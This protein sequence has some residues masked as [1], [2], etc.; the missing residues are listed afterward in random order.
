MQIGKSSISGTLHVAGGHCS[1]WRAG[2]CEARFCAASRGM[3]VA[4]DTAWLADQFYVGVMLEC[5]RRGRR[6]LEAGCVKLA[7]GSCSPWV[8]QL[9]EYPAA[10]TAAV[11]I[12]N[13]RGADCETS[14]SYPIRLDDTTELVCGGVRL[15][16]PGPSSE[17]DAQR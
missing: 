11:G 5:A 9:L 10:G 2:G 7:N 4:A 1:T 17:K 6:G 13:A 8:L 15:G 12:R 3:D 16:S 14:S